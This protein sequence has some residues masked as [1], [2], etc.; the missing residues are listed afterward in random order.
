MQSQ[1]AQH[2]LESAS[3]QWSNR[4]LIAAAM[5]IL[6]LTF[7]PFRFVSHPKLPDDAF[8]LLL[9]GVPG[10][11]S[12][13]LDALLNVLLFV[14]FG[15]GLSEK[16]REK[17]KSR[18]AT[19]LL[20]WIAGALFSY[21][22]EFVQLYIPSRDSGWE[23]VLTNSTGSAAGFLFFAVS[24]S[25]VLRSL[26]R[27]ESV[28]ESFFTVR[29]V[30][31]VLLIYFA[32]WF[33]ISARLQRETRLTNWDPDS[34]LLVG[35]DAIGKP[36]T[37]WKGEISR[38][39]LWDRALPREIAVALTGGASSDAAAPDALA[40]Y[41]FSDGPPFRDRTKSLPDL[42]WS[43]GTPAQGDPNQLV[44][45]GGAWLASTAPASDLVTD[46]QRT[47]QFT[48]HL[49]CRPAE[50]NGSDGRIISISRSTGVVN[51]TIRQEDTSLVFWFRSPLSVRHAQ[52]AW[53]IPNV[54][55][56]NQARSI[57]YSYDGSS[58]SLYIDGKP[59]AIR[60]QLGPGAGLARVFRR[61]KPNE[62]DGYHDIYYALVFFPAGAVLGIVARKVRA[63]RA[64][65]WLSLALMLAVPPVLFEGLLIAVSRRSFSTGDLVLSLALTAG[66]ALWMNADAPPH[67][68]AL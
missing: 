33:A 13:V 21:G 62:L 55:A 39:E 38:L 6:F 47:N 48:I 19:L 28:L 10:K 26:G 27:I 58:L 22:I 45:D 7:F 30:A 5:G 67:T 35:N 32:L 36:L 24:G 50:G 20:V 17:G 46:L 49:V 23:D 64:A 52:L 68:R 57:L 2:N 60:Y 53:Y 1:A 59:E 15:Y 63:H 43:A 16:L 34:Q 37:A 9:G 4:I 40:A 12:G 41:D 65:A 51:L 8:P 44:F 14:P 66:G 54:F 42:S 56:P 61:I 18:G 31:A 3:Q 29:R 11:H 25:A